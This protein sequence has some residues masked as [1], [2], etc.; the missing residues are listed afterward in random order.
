[1]SLPPSSGFDS[2]ASIL[3]MIRDEISALRFE[4]SEFRK[5]NE[6]YHKAFDIVNCVLQDVAESKGLIHMRSTVFGGES[7]GSKAAD[8][9]SDSDD[10]ASSTLPVEVGSYITADDSSS[11][12][13]DEGN[14]S[15]VASALNS[16]VKKSLPTVSTST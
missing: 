9:V 5:S 7:S 11:A 8:N 6:K 15:V 10:L 12:R 4:V 1:M 2:L 3:C 14:L 16:N 13:N